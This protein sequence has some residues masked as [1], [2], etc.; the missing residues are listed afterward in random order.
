MLGYVLWLGLVYE[1]RQEPSL[2]LKVQP[3]A[4]SILLTAFV[5]HQGPWI[6][7]GPVSVRLEPT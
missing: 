3:M 6:H 1:A 2:L 5:D 7:I 4:S